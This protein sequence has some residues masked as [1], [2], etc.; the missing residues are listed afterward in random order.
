[1]S[2]SPKPVTAGQRAIAAAVAQRHE[3]GD[4]HGRILGDLMMVVATYIADMPDLEER[5]EAVDLAVSLL[6]CVVANLVPGVKVA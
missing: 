1:M 4:S 3:A 2:H 5:L 6:P